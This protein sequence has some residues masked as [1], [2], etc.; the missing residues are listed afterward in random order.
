MT[1]PLR[2]RQHVLVV[3][4]KEALTYAQTPMRFSIVSASLMWWAKRIEPSLTGNKPAIKIDMRSLLLDVA[5]Y[6]DTY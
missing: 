2:F 1:Y 3:K 4:E 5:K 6:P